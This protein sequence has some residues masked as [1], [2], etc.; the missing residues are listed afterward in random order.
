MGT[1]LSTYNDLWMPRVL[2]LTESAQNCA[3]RS[4]WIWFIFP[5]IKSLGPSQLARKFAI[6]SREEAKAYL[7][8]PILGLRLIE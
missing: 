5:Q 1:I 8:H 7:E 4:H 2:S 3:K 6:S